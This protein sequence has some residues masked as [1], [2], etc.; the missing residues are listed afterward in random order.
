[1]SLLL[2]QLNDLWGEPQGGCVDSSAA[3]GRV[4][5][6]GRA[7]RPGE[8]F[9]PLVGE[10]FDGHRFLDQLPAK[11][12]AMTVVSAAS[13]Q[14]LPAGLVYWRVEDTLEAYQQLALL[15]RRSLGLPLVAVTGSAGK[16]TTRELI[17]A[18]RPSGLIV[19]SE[20][21]NN[22]DVGVLLPFWVPPPPMRP[23]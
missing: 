19:A 10:R 6:D 11:G 2:Q 13:E 3:L 7:L 17:R 23:W 5:T 20:G 18:A 4:C 12:V 21:N 8:F 9:V 16:T 15:Q 14:P 1:M 22:N